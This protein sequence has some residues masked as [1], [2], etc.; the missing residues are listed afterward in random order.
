M[1]ADVAVAAGVVV[2]EALANTLVF[3]FGPELAAFCGALATGLLTL[4]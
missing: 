1:A 2:N 3:P 4:V